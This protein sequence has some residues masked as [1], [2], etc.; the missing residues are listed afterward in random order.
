MTL[1]FVMNMALDVAKL[2]HRHGD[3]HEHEHHRLGRRRAEIES[4]KTIGVDLVDEDVGCI[5]G[6]AFGNSFDDTE[7]VEEHEND[8]HHQEEESYR[9]E[10]RQHNRIEAFERSRPVDRRRFDQGSGDRQEPGHKEYEVVA[11]LLPGSGHHH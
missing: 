11:D 7:G 8:V 6:S 9:C 5:A 2:H 4:N 3:D 1:T 10:Q